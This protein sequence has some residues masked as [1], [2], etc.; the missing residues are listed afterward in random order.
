MILLLDNSVGKDPLSFIKSM[1]CVF[2]KY[3]IAYVCVNK[4]EPIKSKI[5]GIIISGSSREFSKEGTPYFNLH[6]LNK[7][8]VPVYGICFGCQLLASIYG[9]II[10]HKPYLCNDYLTLPTMV[11]YHYCFSDHIDL[12]QCAVEHI[13]V[14]GKKIHTGFVFKKDVYGTIYHPEYYKDTDSVLLDF[15][16]LCKKYK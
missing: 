8:N 1:I 9:G 4:V 6:Y 15:Y 2:K 5:T 13:V 7:Y 16:K 3:K 10:T 12:P 14:K 11:Q